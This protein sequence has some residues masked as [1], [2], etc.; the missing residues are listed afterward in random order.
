MKLAGF[1][2]V[3]CDE[4]FLDV[5]GHPEPAH[6]AS[7]IREEIFQAT[8]CTASAGIAE[9]LLLA[10]LATKKAK[11]NGQYVIQSHEVLCEIPSI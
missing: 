8:R 9:N 6:L 5:T 10:R 7:R 1:Q 11:P 3:S 2:A 4:A